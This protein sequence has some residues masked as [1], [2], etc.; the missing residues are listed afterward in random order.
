MIKIRN[1]T[2]FYNQGKNISLALSNIDLDLCSNEIVVITGPSGSGKTTLLNVICA[3]DSFDEGKIEIDGVDYNSMTLQELQNYRNKHIGF[4]FQNYNLLD[5][6]TVYQNVMISLELSGYD[7]DKRHHRCLELIEK[8]GLSHRIKH[9]ATKLSGGEKQR[10]VIA[11]ALALDCDILACDE[12]TGNL[13][14]KTALEIVE[15][16]KKVSK[17]KLVLIVTHDYDQ[18]RPIATRHIEVLDGEITLDDKIPNDS[19]NDILKV[20]KEVKFGLKEIIKIAFRD[21][22]SQ[23]KKFVFGL[24]IFLFLTFQFASSFLNI[25]F[26]ISDQITSYY[27]YNYISERRVIVYDKNKKVLDKKALEDIKD[28]KVFYNNLTIDNGVL[29]S[30]EDDLNNDLPNNVF[31]D[32]AWKN[33]DIE[34]KGRLPEKDN[35]IVLYYNSLYYQI[36]DKIFEKS[37]TINDISYSVVGYGSIDN[38][39]LSS[40]TYIY[41]TDQM[42]Y[43]LIEINQKYDHE[44][45]NYTFLL[46]GKTIYAKNGEKNTLWGIPLDEV[47]DLKMMINGFEFSLDKTNFNTENTSENATISLTFTSDLFDK[48]MKENV[49]EASLLLDNANDKQV[50]KALEDL[51]YE[52]I[53]STD[54]LY[55]ND[56]TKALVVFTN[57]ISTVS[58]VFNFGLYFVLGYAVYTLAL[59]SKKKDYTLLHTLGL[60]YKKVRL[61]IFIQAIIQMTLSFILCFIIALI[62]NN[63]LHNDMKLVIDLLFVDFVNFNVV[64]IIK[65]YGVLLLLA[66]LIASKFSKKMLNTTVATNLRRE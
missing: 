7:V 27:P 57:L 10:L 44:M 55:E 20:K 3:Y 58:L 39:L 23:P 26:L 9:K 32:I 22:L 49:Y 37:L 48:V 31:V 4:I 40:D 61:L 36:D 56:D 41:G 14:S 62:L 45:F 46:N 29:L 21:L 52:Y 43:Q 15:L 24:L 34:I 50:F 1:L 66:I 51:G 53:V 12:P 38:N 33:K 6:Y 2:K 16:I 17:D 59:K 64:N 60:S 8:V 28:T 47:N 11:R 19:N 5:S 54:F 25:D 65:I 42:M 63:T 30:F 18:F 13:D 35:E